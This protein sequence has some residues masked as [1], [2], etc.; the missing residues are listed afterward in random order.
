[1]KCILFAGA[2]MASQPD[3]LD[4]MKLGDGPL[5]KEVNERTEYILAHNVK[6]NAWRRDVVADILGNVAR[7]DGVW[8]SVDDLECE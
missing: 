3:H 8:V 5:L 2:L 6:V 7:I 1:M 4:A